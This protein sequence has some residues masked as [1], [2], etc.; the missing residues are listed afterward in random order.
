MN[1]KKRKVLFV[2]DEEENLMVAQA[3]LSK[4]YEVFTASSA[5]EGLKLLNRDQELGCVVSDVRMPDMDGLDFIREARKDHPDLC[6]FLLSGFNETD[7]IAKAIE[8][9]EIKKYFQKPLIRDAIVTSIET[10]C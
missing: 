9:Q 8:T 3:L 4:Y 5:A 7:E 1:D 10:C 6:C 2:D